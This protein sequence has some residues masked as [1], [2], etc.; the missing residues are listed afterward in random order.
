MLERLKRLFA[1]RR[2]P[3]VET[4]QRPSTDTPV[5]LPVGTMTSGVPP[6]VPVDEPAVDQ[7][8]E[9]QR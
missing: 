8:D 6:V 7:P 1:P 3:E 4:V 5:D 9:P 2:G